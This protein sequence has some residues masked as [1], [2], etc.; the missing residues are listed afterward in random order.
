MTKQRTVEEAQQA[1]SDATE[2]VIK[3]GGGVL[4]GS[5]WD[6]SEMAL[7]DV[8]TDIITRAMR[9]GRQRPYKPKGGWRTK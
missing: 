7:D 8:F 9:E 6:T 5:L 2:A 3:E 1:V 4:E